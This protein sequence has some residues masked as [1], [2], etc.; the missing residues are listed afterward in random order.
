M[1]VG[2]DNSDRSLPV[3]MIHDRAFA[4]D[5]KHLAFLDIDNPSNEISFKDVRDHGSYTELTYDPRTRNA[6]K[7][8][9]GERLMRKDLIEVKLPAAIDLDTQGLADEIVINVRKQR[10]FKEKDF[11]DVLDPGPKS[12]MKKVKNKSKRKR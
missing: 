1:A 2:K 9:L 5:I 8:S 12:T 4:V 3:I 6:F 11:K 7:G 10:D